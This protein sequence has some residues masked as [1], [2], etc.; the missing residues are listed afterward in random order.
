M[1]GYLTGAA[2]AVFAIAERGFSAINCCSLHARRLLTSDAW[3]CVNKT[4]RTIFIDFLS[5]TGSLQ[6]RRFAVISIFFS[7]HP[8]A[9]V[10]RTVLKLHPVP[11]ATP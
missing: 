3:S 5:Q 2:N 6:R 1:R 11:L 8:L 7:V 9:D 4:V 10:C